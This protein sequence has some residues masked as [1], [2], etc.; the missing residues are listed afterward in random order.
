[1]GRIRNMFNGKQPNLRLL[2]LLEADTLKKY[3]EPVGTGE[4]LIPSIEY[5]QALADDLMEINTIFLERYHQMRETQ[6]RV[7]EIREAWAPK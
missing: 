7:K 4:N 5:K 1:M 2:K 3:Q 6:E